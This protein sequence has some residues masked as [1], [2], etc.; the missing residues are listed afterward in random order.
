VASRRRCIIVSVLFIV[1]GGPAIGLVY[2][3]LWITRFRVPAAEPWWQMALAGVLIAVGVVL[4][5]ESA[6]RFIVVGRGTLVPTMPTEHLVVSGLYRYVRNPMYVGVLVALAGETILF[7][8]RSM[9]VFM[10][11]MWLG[12]HLFVCLYEE[13]TLKRRYDDEYLEFK[14]HVPRW[15]PR[16]KPWAGPGKAGKSESGTFRSRRVSN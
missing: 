15:L 8:S 10:L 7:R 5:L 14:R 3:P 2:L 13:R 4:A 12:F 16:V 6:R 9:V 11:L 1:F